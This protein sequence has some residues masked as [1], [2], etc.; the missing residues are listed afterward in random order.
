M[1]IQ[2]DKIAAAATSGARRKQT[3][4][5]FS[6]AL[7]GDGVSARGL[8]SGAVRP[9]RVP[10]TLAAGT[11]Q[12]P[13]LVKTTTSQDKVTTR[14]IP[15]GLL[16]PE[17]VRGNAYQRRDLRWTIPD[18]DRLF[19]A[20]DHVA[21]TA[22]TGQVSGVRFDMTPQSITLREEKTTDSSGTERNV[23]H[24]AI[25]Y[26]I[27]MF[28]VED[29]SQ[30]EAW[31]HPARHG[32]RVSVVYSY[33][34]ADTIEE[35]FSSVAAS[36]EKIDAAALDAWLDDYDIHAALVELAEAW[37]G[38]G[39]GQAIADY[40]EQVIDPS[41][42]DPAV[43]QSLVHQMRYLENYSTAV[44][45]SSYRIV[46][47]AIQKVFPDEKARELSRHN[48]NL[49]M[50][51]NLDH[52]AQ[53]KPQL[54]RLPAPR[55]DLV[56]ARFSA[57]QSRAVCTDEPLSLVQAGAGTG[58]STTILGRVDYMTAL[59]VPQDRV[60][61]LSF[62]N[63]AADTLKGR[64]PHIKAMTIAKMVH[65]VYTHNHAGHE[66]STPESMINAIDIFYEHD[67]LAQAF[68]EHLVSTVRGEPGHATAMNS[69]VE[70]NR[71]GVMQILDTIKQVSLDL[72]IMICYQEIE[73]MSE[74]AEI[75]FD[76]LILDEVQDNSIFEFIY[77][78]KY[79][80]KNRKSL[81][82]VGDC[83]QTLYEFRASNPKALNALEASGVFATFQLTTNYRSNQAILDFANV[84]LKDIEA[85]QFAQIQL[86][87]N[88]ITPVTADD[89]RERVWLDY[90]EVKSK[91]EFISNL[92]QYV[93]GK[94]VRAFVDRAMAAG[95]PV[96]VLAYSR[97]DVAAM[98]EGLRAA[99]PKAEVV[100]LVPEK[101]Y[102]STTFSKFVRDYWNDIKQVAPKSAAHAIAS[103]M[104]KNLDS[105]EGGKSG[106]ASAGMRRSVN[107]M[108]HKWWVTNSYSV[109][110]WFN[111]V[112]RGLITN[113]V[114]F[115]RLRQSLLRH[116]V[117]HNGMK[118][119][120][121]STRN[122]QRKEENL[123]KKADI[124]VS[125]IHSAKGMEF[126][127]T[128]VLHNYDSNMDE[129]DKRMYYVAFTRAQKTELVVSYGTLVNPGVVS[130][131]NTLI[132]QLEEADAQRAALAAQA[133]LMTA[134]AGTDQDE[135]QD[136]TDVGAPGSEASV[137]D[138]P[139]A[140]AQAAQAAPSGADSSDQ[141]AE[142]DYDPSDALAAL[143]LTLAPST[144]A[145]DPTG[146]TGPEDPS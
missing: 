10:V 105:L 122:K 117:D 68:R 113:E 96:A 64:N 73:T 71:D 84:A 87:S 34:P 24:L 27:R 29:P 9:N 17:L 67:D 118:E 102:T 146:S 74:P 82:M 13:V 145:A 43:F 98:E 120:L 15:V 57:Q 30:D 132:D 8:L 41:N 69:F 49:M 110:S 81:Y 48:V 38:D 20:R 99:Y 128:I 86:Q 2:I 136:G 60:M 16:N 76:H 40:I 14:N 135:D 58:K 143:G 106:S 103:E 53:V 77:V 91:T 112:Q 133:S 104:S 39:I 75:S 100:N 63:S 139:A 134:A 130:D 46:H 21:A 33:Q 50:N 137:A 83:S 79:V 126:P 26:M 5:F 119:R 121:V 62:T 52:L 95:E 12:P 124:F 109:N 80:A 3:P 93:R 7:T 116:E 142:G 36:N 70:N 107:E 140:A 25:N 141:G 114:F 108:L 4:K 31:V 129:D 32:N 42:V 51:E 125:T 94:R 54:N 59:G 65:M 44:A 19:T 123:G 101:N 90:T 55:T 1:P 45:L 89:M 66:P 47:E 72:E 23:R 11:S 88:D 111:E 78:L 37:T 131:Y 18:E 144:P 138:E 97:R 92:P 85:N 127:H 61:A 35:M 28:V 22:G 6:S 115:E 56:P